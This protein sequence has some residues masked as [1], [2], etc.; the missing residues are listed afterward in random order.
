[1][2]NK[3]KDDLVLPVVVLLVVVI[4]AAMGSIYGVSIGHQEACASLHLEYV[5]DRCMKVT[6][7]EIK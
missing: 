5:K 2:R 1:M 7:E 6:R 3:M 4:C